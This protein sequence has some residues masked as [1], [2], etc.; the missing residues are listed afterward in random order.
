VRKNLALAKLRAG[1]VTVGLHVGYASPDLAEQAAHTGFDWVWLD[2]QHGEWTEVPLNN[3]LARF[4]AVESIPIVRVRSQDVGLVNRALD[5]GAMGVMVPM[6][7]NAEQARA[8]AQAVF[9]P[10]LGRRSAG[11][12]RLNL[13]AGS[14]KLDYYANANEEMMLV[15]QV[16]TEEA[17]ANV[18]EIMA[19]PGVA[20][21]L[22]G[23]RDLSLDVEAHGHDQA[24]HERLVEQVVAASKET[25]T[26]A[27]CLCTGQQMAERRVAQGF[28]FVSLGTV[29]QIV[30][31]RMQEM[32]A[33]SRE[34]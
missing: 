32:F 14:D 29:T 24:H 12:P 5:M 31:D 7:Q 11:G 30:A 3:A 23:P 33:Y 8:T 10:P 28:R 20:A 21:V 9:Y 6:V 16:E 13:I 17:V 22:I 4:L 1:K 19:V 34:W 25:G 27:G 26:A 18:A 15:L 2:A